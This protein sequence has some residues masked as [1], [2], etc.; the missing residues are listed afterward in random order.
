MKTNPFAPRVWRRYRGILG[1]DLTR[2]RMVEEIGRSAQRVLEDH[3]GEELRFAMEDIV[4]L[5]TEV[6]KLERKMEES[7][8]GFLRR[9]SENL[10]KPKSWWT[11]IKQALFKAFFK[12]LAGAGHG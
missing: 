1:D 3:P 5:A 9:M 4:Y 12:H 11:R 8:V 7:A 6:E 2:A 10:V